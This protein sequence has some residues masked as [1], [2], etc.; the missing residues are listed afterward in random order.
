[1][2]LPILLDLARRTEFGRSRQM[3]VDSLWRFRKD[4]SV[5]SALV[6]LCED[7][8]VC[9]HAMSAY[10]RTVGNETAIKL[11]TSLEGHNDPQVRV[12]AKRERAKAQKSLQSRL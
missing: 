4:Q 7:P 1:V 8:D 10:R 11:L 12:Q 2:H 6:P 9:L 5:A 3:L